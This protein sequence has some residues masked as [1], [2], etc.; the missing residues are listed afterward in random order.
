VEIEEQSLPVPAPDESNESETPA[1]VSEPEEPA[2]ITLTPEELQRVAAEF[3]SLTPL[4]SHIKNQYKDDLPGIRKKRYIRVLTTFSKT[5]FFVQGTKAFGYEYSLLKGY[6]Q[7][8]NREHTKDDLR[9]VMEFIPVSRDRLIPLL[10]NGWGDIAAAGLTITPERKKVGDFTEPYLTHVDELVVTNKK[11]EVLETLEDLS[12]REIFVRPSSSYYESLVS[13]NRDLQKKGLPPVK[14]GKAD[15][16]LEAEDILEMIDAGAME[17]TVMDSHVAELWSSV[18]ENL[19]VLYDLKVRAGGEIAWMVRNENPLLKE[20]LNA[21]LKTHRKGTLLGNI[22]LRR[23]FQKNKWIRNPFNRQG[24][25][26]KDD[27]IRTL[28]K[29]AAFYGFDWLLIMAVAYQESRLDHNKENPCGAVGIMQVRPTTARDKQ[30]NIPNIHLLEDNIH[31]GVKYLAFLRK[32]YYS[33]DRLDPQDGIRFALASYNAGP[34]K[35]RMV[36][37]LAKQMG[38]NP[39]IWFRNVEYAAL[40]L[41]GQETVQYVSNVNKYYV[42]FKFNQKN[43]KKR[44]ERSERSEVKQSL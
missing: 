29:H 38:Y 13:L 4:H 11:V 6:E 28:K 24:F 7:F 31:A 9:V 25:D 39:D 3:A 14:I 18:F 12:G 40:K 8:L 16:S 1:S 15:E 10:I 42:L 33:Q 35:I 26:R 41:I 5:N 23:Y 2:P 43:E 20:S 27:V 21:F 17:I 22:Y 37:R 32:R 34:R 44:S 36:R 19:K 30:V